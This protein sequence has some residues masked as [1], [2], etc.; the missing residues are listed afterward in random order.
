MPLDVM[1]LETSKS[2]NHFL[3]ALAFLRDVVLAVH[4]RIA[5]N[6][7]GAATDDG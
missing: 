3:A 7:L 2:V 1:M 5:G 6:V 4:Y